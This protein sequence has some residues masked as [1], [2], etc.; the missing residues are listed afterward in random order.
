MVLLWRSMRKLVCREPRC[1]SS[2]ATLKSELLEN[3]FIGIV[4]QRFG[5]EW[6]LCHNQRTFTWFHIQT[7]TSQ[8]T[9]PDIH[10]TLPIGQI[11]TFKWSSVMQQR[12]IQV[13]IHFVPDHPCHC[14]M[15][16]YTCCAIRILDCHTSAAQYTCFDFASAI[17][18]QYN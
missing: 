4:L 18:D 14:H 17:V 12:T 1:W 2:Q 3:Y 9:V 7:G 5:G 15:F 13:T 10:F 16:G 8:D 6:C 11:P